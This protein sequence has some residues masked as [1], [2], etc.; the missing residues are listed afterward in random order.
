MATASVPLHQTNEAAHE[1]LRAYCRTHSVRL[2]RGARCPHSVAG[3]RCSS[4]SPSSCALLHSEV[5]DHLQH[6][7]SR[8][9]PRA[10]ACLI[11]TPYLPHE[12]VAHFLAQKVAAPLGLIVRT[13]PPSLSWWHD[14]TPQ[15]EFWRGD[16]DVRWLRTGVERW[17]CHLGKSADDVLLYVP[18][19][20]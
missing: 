5:F 16:V 8:R 20:D 11:S 6:F 2:Q 15:T 10:T 17:A 7:T 1:R 12:A 19:R 13:L 3:V 4:G 18:A 9:W 14:G